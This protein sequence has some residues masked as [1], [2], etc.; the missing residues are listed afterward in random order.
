[1][2]SKNQLNWEQNGPIFNFAIFDNENRLVGMVEANTNYEE[3]EGIKE[4]NENI[5]YVIYP[6]ARGKG[7]APKAT[8]LMADFLKSKGIKRGVIRVNPE[9]RE[10][11]NV[12]LHVGFV[13]EEIIT[14]K[15][16]EK[17]VVFIKNLN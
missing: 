15:N 9:N 5:S 11:L 8:G 13:E 6:F 14:L 10:S 3:V 4:G 2:D 16:G 12:P 17:S 7:Y 1:M